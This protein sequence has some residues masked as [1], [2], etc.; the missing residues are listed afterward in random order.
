MNDIFIEQLVKRHKTKNDNLKVIFSFVATIVAS[1]IAL[2]VFT[3]LFPFLLFVGM[4]ISYYYSTMMNKEFEYSFTN[5][6]FDVDC[7]YNRQ[8]RKRIYSLDLKQSEIIYGI[9]NTEY[10][11]KYSELKPIDLSSGLNSENCY[12][13]IIKIDDKLQKFIIEPNETIVDAF[14]QKLGR[15]I[16]IKNI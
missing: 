14:E 8:K 3:P 12:I 11:N 16:F 7:I 1:L 4:F 9:N 10:I 6:E 13:I 5:N 2:A 15:R